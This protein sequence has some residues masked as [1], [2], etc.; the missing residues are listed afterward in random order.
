MNS[1][2]VIEPTG[3]YAHALMVIGLV[4]EKVVFISGD[5][6]ITPI[7]CTKTVTVADCKRVPWLSKATA[8]KL[9]VPGGALV[10]I[11]L[12]GSFVTEA[13]RLPPR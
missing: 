2:L 1:I 13:T 5:R 11:T 7:F 8:K 9:L 4:V 3:K 10:T 6:I 12:K